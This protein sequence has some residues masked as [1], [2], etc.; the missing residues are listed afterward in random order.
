[1]SNLCT[2]L[3]TVEGISCDGSRWERYSENV[4]AGAAEEGGRRKKGQVGV[5][6]GVKGNR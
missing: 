3:G 5:G 4:R 1:M 2:V 6:G